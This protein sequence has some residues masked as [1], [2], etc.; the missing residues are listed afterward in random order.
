MTN[1]SELGNTKD[2]SIGRNKI[3]FYIKNA[4][5]F[6]EKAPLFCKL[7][8]C[9]P[10]GLKFKSFFNFVFVKFK[11]PIYFHSHV[12]DH[13]LNLFQNHGGP[14]I[15]IDSKKLRTKGKWHVPKL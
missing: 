4:G 5:C 12:K 2:K 11:Q 10:T 8:T 6:H 9:N 3:S 1:A 14:Q 7:K 15:L 13:L